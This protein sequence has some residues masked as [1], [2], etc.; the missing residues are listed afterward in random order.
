M[1]IIMFVIVRMI[2][3]QLRSIKTKHNPLLNEWN[4]WRPCVWAQQQTDTNAM[5]PTQIIPYLRR[6]SRKRLLESDT[7]KKT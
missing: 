1:E 5:K 2:Q 6:I 4:E 3:I 7:K